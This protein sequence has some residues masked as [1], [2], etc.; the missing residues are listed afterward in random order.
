MKDDN[1]RIFVRKPQPT[2]KIKQYP[3]PMTMVAKNKGGKKTA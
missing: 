2:P 1:K 3:K